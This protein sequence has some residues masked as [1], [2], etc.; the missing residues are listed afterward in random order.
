MLIIAH[1]LESVATAQ[2]ILV[3]NDGRIVESGSHE[4]L[5]A[6]NGLYAETSALYHELM[7]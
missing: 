4:V 2:R 1:R 5:L 7:P 3:L 6:Q